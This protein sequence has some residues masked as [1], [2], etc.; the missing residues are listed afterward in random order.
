MN[1]VSNH[2]EYVWH[3]KLSSEVEG[4]ANADAL[5]EMVREQVGALLRCVTFTSNGADLRVTGF[6]F[7]DEPDCEHAIRAQLPAR[8][9]GDADSESSL[10]GEHDR[11]GSGGEPV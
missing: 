7:I 9:P 6:R 4:D 2:P 10:G 1:E 5:T 8:Q 11:T 3:F